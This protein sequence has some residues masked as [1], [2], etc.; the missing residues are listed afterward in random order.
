MIKKKF[1]WAIISLLKIND[2]RNIQT[3][4]LVSIG[5]YIYIDLITFSKKIKKKKGALKSSIQSALLL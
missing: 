4:K 5:M 1:S 2:Y 3:I